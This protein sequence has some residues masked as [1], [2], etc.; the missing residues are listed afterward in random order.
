MC[1]VTK[2]VI[3]LRIRKLQIRNHFKGSWPYYFG[4]SIFFSVLFFGLYKEYKYHLYYNDPEVEIRYTIATITGFEPGSK[5]PPY[6]DFEFSVN[7]KE[8]NG[9]HSLTD[10]LRKKSSLEMSSF[11]LKKYIVEYPEKDPSYARLLL[12]EPVSAEKLNIP[13]SGWK[14]IPE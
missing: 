11:L 6:F 10:E 12:N 1:L 7:G 2:L 5:S 9:I 4:G 8:Y 3:P 14:E 13:Y